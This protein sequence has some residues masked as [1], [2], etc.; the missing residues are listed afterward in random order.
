MLNI[1]ETVRDRDIVSMEC[2]CP[3]LNS[4]ISNDL[5]WSWVTYRNIQWH[6]ASRGLSATAEVLVPQ[7]RECRRRA[8]EIAVR[9]VAL[10]NLYVMMETSRKT[11]QRNAMQCSAPQVPPARTSPKLADLR[12]CRKIQD[13]SNCLRRQHAAGCR[14]LLRYRLCFAT[15]LSKG[16]NA[17]GAVR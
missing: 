10:R 9:C 14:K 3:I 7:V 5:E 4:V 12:E 11:M 15:F 8:G 1:P 16:K 17:W 2:T 6:E 13:S